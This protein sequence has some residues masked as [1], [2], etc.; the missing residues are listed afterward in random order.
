MRETVC[1]TEDLQIDAGRT[2]NDLTAMTTNIY[3]GFESEDFSVERDMTVSE[4]FDTIVEHVDTFREA[5]AVADILDSIWTAGS[6]EGNG[7]RVWFVKREL[8]PTL[9]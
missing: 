6:Y 2:V 9:N 1:V 5:M 4:L 7:W 8:K 3:A